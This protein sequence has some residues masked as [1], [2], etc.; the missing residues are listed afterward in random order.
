M[1]DDEPKYESTHKTHNDDEVPG[2]RGGSAEACE[3]LA[4]QLSSIARVTNTSDSLILPSCVLPWNK[5]QPR[6]IT[7]HYNVHKNIITSAVIIRRETLGSELDGTL[8]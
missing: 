2:S 7:S 6:I 5:T 8:Y 3:S 1:L 4:S